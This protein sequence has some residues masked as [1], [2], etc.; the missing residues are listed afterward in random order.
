[1]CQGRRGKLG[2]LGLTAVLG[3]AA[4]AAAQEALLPASPAT[5]STTETLRVETRL[6]DMVFSVRDSHGRLVKNLRREDFSVLDN[7]QH[8]PIT[9]FV[10]EFDRPLTLAVVFDKSA[11]VQS[12]FDFQKQ[13]TD[14]FL[15]GVVRPG[16]DRV[17][18]IAVD[19]Q[20]HLL[21]PFTNRPEQ[22][23]QALA[24]LQAQGGTA[25]FD[26]ARL[27]IEE[28]LSQ[29][30]PVRKILILVTDGED[31]VSRAT[32]SEVL[33]LALYHN[34][35]VYSLGVKPDGPGRHRRAHRH[36]TRLGAETGGAALFPKEE[37]KELAQL[38]AVL[39]DELRHQYSLGYPLPL[40]EGRLFHQVDIKAGKK[41][42]RVHTRRGYYTEFSQERSLGPSTTR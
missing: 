29:P 34:V 19:K 23:K 37:P 35:V 8:Q 27:A 38:F 39:A 24:P 31:T 36:L 17:L 15:R 4:A 13:A 40:G 33:A 3:L 22:I 25:L 1:M 12:H 7:G 5:A 30:G 21:V 14:E 18:L 20:P 42:Y 6:V 9:Q 32:E 11:S 2:W 16:R 26:A 28:H 41:D 10:E